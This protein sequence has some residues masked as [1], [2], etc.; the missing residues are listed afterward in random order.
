MKKEKERENCPSQ[1]GISSKTN[2][3]Q[4]GR[5]KSDWRYNMRIVP[6]GEVVVG[7]YLEEGVEG[8]AAE[9][10]GDVVREGV[11]CYVLHS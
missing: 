5:L 10:E 3:C 1:G 9:A 2:S 7:E 6:D 8:A 11:Q 4:G